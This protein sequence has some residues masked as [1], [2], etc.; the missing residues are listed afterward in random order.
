MNKREA[1]FLSAFMLFLGIVIGFLSSPVKHGLS[2][3]N[4]SGNTYCGEDDCCEDMD[5]YK[6]EDDMPF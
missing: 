6:D 4:N 5:E 3:G 1:F 2:I